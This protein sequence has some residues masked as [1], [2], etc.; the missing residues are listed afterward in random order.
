MLHIV[1]QMVLHAGTSP[2]VS[3]IVLTLMLVVLGLVLIGIGFGFLVKSKDGVLLHR[4]SLSV[5]AALALAGV[6]LVMLP[7]AYRFYIDPDVEFF[8][9]LSIVTIIHGVVG[10]PAIVTGMIYA[11]GDLPENRRKWMRIT[12]FF[13]LA[14]VALGIVLYLLMML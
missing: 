5:S 13:W 7:S 2:V 11:F 4:W 8:S 10:F 3:Q 12:A 14:T 9:P 1:D 6:F